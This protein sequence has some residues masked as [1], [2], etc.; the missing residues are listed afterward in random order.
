MILADVD[1]YESQTKD[2]DYFRVTS[3]RQWKIKVSQKANG[4]RSEPYGFRPH[5]CATVDK[6]AHAKK[7]DNLIKSNLRVSIFS[8][9]G[10]QVLLLFWQLGAV[11]LL[12]VSAGNAAAPHDFRQTLHGDGRGAVGRVQ[13]L[14]RG[15][16]LVPRF[17]GVG[18]RLPGF[19]RLEDRAVRV[20]AGVDAALLQR[21][22]LPVVVARH[23]AAAGSAGSAA[24]GRWPRGL[25]VC[26]SV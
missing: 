7:K 24:P 13:A 2:L 26:W 21:R 5:F 11:R 14:L 3:L 20:N 1:N 4:S 8:D 17:S 6:P 22:I 9:G 10:Q 19:D 15:G 16:K 25:Q 18:D 23:A 12:L